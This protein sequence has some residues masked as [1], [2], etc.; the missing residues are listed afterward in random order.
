MDVAV[1]GTAGA[2]GRQLAV[3]L[4]ERRIVP[5]D[6]RL[7]LVGHRGGPSEKELWGLRAADHAVAAS[8]DATLGG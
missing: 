7:Q 4:L 1:V 2:C 5:H 6:A 3:H 8:L